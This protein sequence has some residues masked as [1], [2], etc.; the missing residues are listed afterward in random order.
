MAG[1]RRPRARVQVVGAAALGVLSLLGVCLPGV[2]DPAAALAGGRVATVLPAPVRSVAGR[3]RGGLDPAQAAARAVAFAFAQVGKP[4]AWGGQ[5]PDNFDCS[6]L[7]MRSF[8][9]AGLE[10]GRT[11]RRQYTYSDTTRVPLVNL[12]PGDLVFWGSA[13][14]DPNSVYHVALYLGSGMVIAAPHPG[15]VVQLEP[16]HTTNLMP[17]VVRPLGT[18]PHGFFPVDTHWSAA[19]TELVQY[20]LRANGFPV[21]VD[22]IMSV[23]TRTAVRQLQLRMWMGSRG[24]VGAVTWGYLIT[25]GVLTS[26][27]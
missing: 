22:G 8:E 25:H 2:D 10:I 14:N 20:R 6:G 27:V 3:V 21:Q 13:A 17:F 19:Q 11:S 16:L 5:G 24:Q 18:L 15:T 4:Y 12:Q 23:L 26:R 1:A 7:T 9:A